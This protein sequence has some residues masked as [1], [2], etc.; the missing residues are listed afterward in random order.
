MDN[1]TLE[2]LLSEEEI[3]QQMSDITK[4]YITERSALRAAFSGLSKLEA[5]AQLAITFLEPDLLTNTDAKKW[6][7]RAKTEGTKL[8]VADKEAIVTIECQEKRI[9]YDL[10]KFDCDSSD[11]Q[12]AKLESQL[13]FLQSLMKFTGAT[14]RQ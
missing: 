10:C 12:F 6:L 3:R 14:E 11:K 7:T 13:S 9:A 4:R 1:D 2:Q 8:T 5:Q